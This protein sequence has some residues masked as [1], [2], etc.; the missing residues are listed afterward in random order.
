MRIFACLLLLAACGDDAA[1]LDADATEPIDASELADARP[2]TPPA[3]EATTPVDDAPGAEPTTVVSATF[4]EPMDPATIDGA[5]FTVSD[6]DGPIAGQVDYDA[7]SRTARFVPARRLALRGR[8]TARL[9]D[10]IADRDGAPLADDHVWTFAVRDGAWEAPALLESDDTENARVP[11]VAFAPDGTAI[12]VFE[13]HGDTWY[14]RFDGV[15]SA[16]ALLAADVTPQRLAFDGEGNA[17]VV[18]YRREPGLTTMIASVLASRYVPGAGW[19]APELIETSA[20]SAQDAQLVVSPDGTATVA[21]VDTSGDSILYNRYQ[22][23]SG[24]GAAEALRSG[25]GEPTRPRL[26]AGPGGV[27]FATWEEFDSASWLRRVWTRRFVPGTGWAEPESIELEGNQ[28]GTN[29]EIAALPDGGAILVFL[30]LTATGNLVRATRFTPAAGWGPI[31]TLGSAVTPPSLAI[32]AAGDAFAAWAF[33]NGTVSDVHV[34]RY[35]PGIGWGSVSLVESS[36]VNAS[37]PRV[38]VDPAGNAVTLFVHQTP[39]HAD[40]WANRSL[41]GSGWG[42]AEPV[43]AGEGSVDT[44]FSLAIAADGSALVVWPQLVGSRID[45]HFARFQ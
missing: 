26:A 41:P 2:N 31:E 10:A 11:H 33:S 23:G 1:D 42:V 15:W 39:G 44:V 43:E 5:S 28:W 36:D 9:S 25:A 27:V 3:V 32:D 13:Q 35:A 19:S 8:Y 45:V 14:A 4:S 16:P 38:A 40:L 24:W 21:W 30:E 29:S 12:A 20:A 6:A 17:I 18:L 34:I 22:P 7:P 37:F